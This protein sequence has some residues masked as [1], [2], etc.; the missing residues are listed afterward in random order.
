[1]GASGA[2]HQFVERADIQGIDQQVIEKRP[3]PWLEP[4]A[5]GSARTARQ[6]PT[7]PAP[8]LPASCRSEGGVAWLPG[9]LFDREHQGTN[10][11]S[12]T[13]ESKTNPCGG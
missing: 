12:R 3:P 1:M 5:A 8:G 13:S 4:I 2:R 10:G 7:W 9:R 6:P 11:T